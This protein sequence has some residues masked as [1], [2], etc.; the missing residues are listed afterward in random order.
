MS[1]FPRISNPF[2][3]MLLLP[4]AITAPLKDCVARLRNVRRTPCGSGTR[5]VTV[6]FVSNVAYPSNYVAKM[7]VD[8]STSNYPTSILRSWEV[9]KARR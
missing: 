2:P 5:A 3:S 1:G 9:S 4:D 7:L 8:R 6:R